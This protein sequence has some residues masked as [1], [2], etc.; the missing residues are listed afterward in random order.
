[1][2]RNSDERCA[3]VRSFV[4]SAQPSAGST[5]AQILGLMVNW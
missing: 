3:V 4:K 2:L 5:F 1:M